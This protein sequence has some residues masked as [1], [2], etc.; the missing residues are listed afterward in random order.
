M[1]YWEIAKII[2]TELNFDTL[3]VAIPV[4]TTANKGGCLGYSYV[5]GFLSKPVGV[6]DLLIIHRLLKGSKPELIC[7][8]NPNHIS[9]VKTG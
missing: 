5:D 2:K 1:K 9:P 3:I 6:S 4:R 8:I 7:E